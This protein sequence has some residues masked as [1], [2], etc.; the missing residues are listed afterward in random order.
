LINPAPKQFDLLGRKFL[1]RFRRWHDFRRII[2]QDPCDDCAGFRVS[3]L[4]GTVFDCFVARIETEIRLAA[5]LVRTMASEA[6]VG[7]DR[8]NIAVKLDLFVGLGGSGRNRHTYQS[9]GQSGPKNG[10]IRSSHAIVSIQ[11]AMKM[12]ECTWWEHH[13]V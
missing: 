1:S 3:G 4:D 6:G 8:A 10:T 5:M 9:N 2:A 11:G 12:Q 7:Q 13:Q